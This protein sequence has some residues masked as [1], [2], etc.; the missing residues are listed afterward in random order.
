MNKDKR[1]KLLGIITI[2]L[3]LLSIFISSPT[4]ADSWDYTLPVWLDHEVG[5]SSRYRAD[6][7]PF[8]HEYWGEYEQGQWWNIVSQY[9]PP[10][11]VWTDTSHNSRRRLSENVNPITG[12]RQDWSEWRY[13]D[14]GWDFRVAYLGEGE[15]TWRQEDLRSQY[16][17][18][19]EQSFGY[20]KIMFGFR[21][22]P[23]LQGKVLK[24][25]TVDVQNAYDDNIDYYALNGTPPDPEE[26]YLE[27]G[28]GRLVFNLGGYLYPGEILEANITI[29]G[30]LKNDAGEQIRYERWKRSWDRD[31]KNI[32]QFSAPRLPEVD[33]SIA[34]IKVVQVI[35]DVSLIKD[36][37]TMVRVFVSLG[38]DLEEIDD[39]KIELDYNGTKHT[40]QPQTVKKDYIKL[41]KYQAKDTFNFYVPA[42][43]TIGTIQV[44]AT[45]DHG[46]E[47][48]ESNENNNSLPLP[49]TLSVVKVK[50]GLRYIYLPLG[51]GAWQN[52]TNIPTAP[53][54]IP[55][56]EFLVGVYP[57][58]NSQVTPIYQNNVFQIDIPWWMSPWRALYA[59]A[60]LSKLQKSLPNVDH[61]VG[62]VPYGWI[63]HLP[64]TPH[65]IGISSAL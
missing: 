32:Q 47:I 5:S 17:W 38:G 4:L 35:Q 8:W 58:P 33:L 56:N 36:K 21:I 62:V 12:E 6:E 29:T 44:N 20:S 51:V 7:E 45:V 27:N 54:G 37:E 34:D 24:I 55:N 25:F 48:I 9:P 16:G 26:S 19:E 61:I 63:P 1:D 50:R 57:L 49:K 60:E 22:P 64:L 3:A 15:S 10:G 30:P 14:S 43:T 46:E 59:L 13:L 39:I 41:E 42:P 65:L 2:I 23:V 31:Y 53:T 40:S 11:D 28:Q 52:A 18:S